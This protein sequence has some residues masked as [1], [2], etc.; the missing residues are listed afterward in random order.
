MIFA[1]QCRL[2]TIEDK[3]ALYALW[4]KTFG[5]E[6]AVIDRFFQC[7]TPNEIVVC[8]ENGNPVSALY[9][10]R[11]ELRCGEKT[12][13]AAYIYAAATDT[14]YRG[15]GLMTALL[16]FAA[17]NA[18]RQSLDGLY[19]V[20]AERTL[21]DYYGARGFVTAFF[22]KLVQYSKSELKALYENPATVLPISA[23]QFFKAREQALQEIWHPA[24]SQTILDFSLFLNK[25][26]GVETLLTDCGYA[27]YETEENTVQVTDFCCEKGKEA[28]LLGALLQ[29]T[30]AAKFA[31]SMPVPRQFGTA[32][33][34]IVPAGM[35][36]PLSKSAQ[37]TELQNGYIGITLG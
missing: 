12:L 31:L 4:Q 27:V 7:V 15:R 9:M 35:W 20:P 1:V 33:G 2:A 24:Y 36:Q 16:Q 37:Q 28:A 22:K 34:K 26:Y 30:D 21:F 25:R 18:Q 11:V 29:K 13:S 17:E 19:L 5:D 8:G 10:P 14:A 32:S 3:T 6:P 23:S